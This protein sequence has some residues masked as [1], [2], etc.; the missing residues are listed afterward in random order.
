MV[1]L[2]WWTGLEETELAVRRHRSK[3]IGREL[4]YILNLANSIMGV[5]L[6]AMPF[7]F[8]RCGIFLGTILL[9][10]STYL[11]TVTCG[12]L[13]KA[14]ITSKRRSYEFLGEYLKRPLLSRYKIDLK[15]YLE[16]PQVSTFTKVYKQPKCGL[17]TYQLFLHV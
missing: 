16:L 9:L 12:L 17:L 11:T 8:M 10:V 14:G 4:P 2:A 15:F 3:M 13:V 5:S 6:L 1:A 7:C